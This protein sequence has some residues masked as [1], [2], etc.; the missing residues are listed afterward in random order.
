MSSLNVP[1]IGNLSPTVTS[2]Y[3]T[4]PDI[5]VFDAVRDAKTFD[6]SCP[7][8]GHPP[9]RAWSAFCSHQAKP[10]EGE[11]ELGL[12]CCDKLKECGGV[13]EQPAHSRL[14][15]AAGSKS[16]TVP[17]GECDGAYPTDYLE[18]VGIVL[19]LLRT[20]QRQALADRYLDRLSDRE[21]AAMEGVKTNRHRVPKMIWLA[22]SGK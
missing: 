22:R 5:D 2:V 14:F 18:K 8:V 7:I 13:I 21:I 16:C 9:C 3:K 19:S 1:E 20:D 17:S 11:K 12:W 6:G 10:T 4:L 15:E